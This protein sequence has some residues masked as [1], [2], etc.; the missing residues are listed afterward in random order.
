MKITKDIP[1]LGVIQFGVIDRRTNLLQIRPTTKCNLRC[2]FCS[3]A[4]G[5]HPV[6][7]EIL[8]DYLIKWVRYVVKLKECNEIE[9]NIDSV[10]EPT[11]YPDL[12]NLIEGLKK[13]PEIKLISMQTNGTSLKNIKELENAG[14]NRINLSIHALEKNLAKK[15]SGADYNIDN[16][17]NIIKEIKKTRI[18]LNLTPVYL[19]KVNDKEIPKLI[20]LAESLKCNILIQKY[21]AYRYSRKLKKA[22]R[23]SWYRFYKQLEAWER[24]YNIKLKYGNFKYN[25]KKT[26]PIPKAFRTNETLTAEIILPGWYKGQ[27][28]AAAKNRLIT[29]QNCNKKMHSRARIR[30]TSNDNNI[31]LAKLV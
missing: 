19:P 20:R 30:I 9:A 10:G 18:E 28:I 12:I 2:L 21:E 1:L 4:A 16:I 29:I 8:S 7:Y 11:A 5:K 25:I 6:E 23:I 15:L 22:E 3:T 14:L 31:Y 13:I 27:M 17:L 26:K 24:E